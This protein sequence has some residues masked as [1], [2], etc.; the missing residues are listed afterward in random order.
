M[1]VLSA[2]QFE[3]D[4]L[5]AIFKHAQDMSW[6]LNPSND[7]RRELAERHV[8]QQVCSLFYEP[9]TRTRIS[10][11][12]AAAKLGMGVI[13][14]ENA[15][16]FSSAAKGETLE[17][18]IRVLDGYGFSA[19]IMRH[20]ETGAAN[21]AAAVSKTP[22]IN[23]GDGAGEHPTQSLLDVFT[24]YDSFKRV[25]DLNIVIGGDLKYGR[26]ARSLAK[27]LA[28]YDNNHITFISVP[29]FQIGDDI[30]TLLDESGTTYT[31]TSDM[32]EPMHDADVVYWTRLQE[33]RISEADDLP[34]ESLT[35]N[36][37]TLEILP[38]DSIIMHPLPRVGEI[39]PAIDSDP[40]A[41]YFKQAEN[42]LYVRMALLDAIG[43]GNPY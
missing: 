24:I 31:E 3:R 38:K 42:G 8:G 12:S 21:R 34:S 41:Q 10:F 40:R 18:T 16:L 25:D 37:G 26:T 1:H 9:S 23:A 6:E 22:V 4:T 27:I 28:K 29:E 13:S 43:H 19:I 5:G 30:K 11:E 15:E 2:D 35:I 14:T 36:A 7:H 17:D 20:K 32:H 39:D 33:E